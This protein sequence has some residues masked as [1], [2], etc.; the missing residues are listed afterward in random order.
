MNQAITSG[1]NAAF[2]DSDMVSNPFVMG[3]KT[4]MLTPSADPNAW[5]PT[6][7]SPVAALPVKVLTSF[8]PFDKLEQALLGSRGAKPTGSAPELFTE[9][10]NSIF[11]AHVTRL[12]SLL[13]LDERNGQYASAVKNAIQVMAYNGDLDPDKVYDDTTKS[14]LM[15][16][17]G[18]TAFG[19][20]GLRFIL[21]FGIPASPELVQDVN[22]SP[23][24]RNLN[25]KS[26]RRGYTELLTRF[27]GDADKATAAWFKLN[28]KL[29]PFTVSSTE[30]G[31]QT[32]PSLTVQAGQWM[33]DNAD[34]VKKNPEASV[35]LAP[36]AGE[37][38]FATYALAKS[39]G[40]IK[41]KTAED[42]FLQ[43]ITV[44][45]Y[46]VYLNTRDS[47]EQALVGARSTQERNQLDEL[48][49]K[50]RKEMY[51]ANPFLAVRVNSLSD[52]SN[53]EQKRFV[54]NSTRKAVED[55]YKNRKSM[56]SPN[57]D[58][59]S[60]MIKTY[61]AAMADITPLVGK[62]D[63]YSESVRRQYREQLRQILKN[64]AGDDV[65]A[66]AFYDTILDR[67]IGG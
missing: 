42:M 39:K 7:A 20:L 56:I 25:L 16:K 30:A 67:L 4:L 24:A 36:R 45:D 51:D 23:E 62:T 33:N 52:K 21:G 57:V 35:F 9:L 37:F 54:L 2:G 31:K 55:I 8:A 12:L 28:P 18:W 65:N 29:M 53:I 27:N 58:L 44:K 19:I 22:L 13:P 43:T 59:I 3:G 10:F 63:S 5:L 46:F 47:Y 64:A 11:P 26:L 61:D 17:V 60:S 34:F 14:E 48:W 32:Y 6:F 15:D 38:S 40:F 66:K 1:V 49:N 50:L 41:G